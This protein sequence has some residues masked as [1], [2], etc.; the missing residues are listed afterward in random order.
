VSQFIVSETENKYEAIKELQN[1]HLDASFTIGSESSNAINVA[2]QLKK[3]KAQSSLAARR[4]VRCYLSDA[5]TGA[6]VVGTAP[7]SGGAIGTNGKIINQPVSG[8]IFDVIT[9]T[10]GQFDITFTESGAKTMYLNV[11]MPNGRIVTS[12]AITFT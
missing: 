6:D 7:S 8:K 3:D 12:G 10:S 5:N 11:I 2:V 1:A 9:T 4:Y